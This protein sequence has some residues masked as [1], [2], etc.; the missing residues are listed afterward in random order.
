MSGSEHITLVGQLNTTGNT[1]KDG[2]TG[3]THPTA[4]TTHTTAGIMLQIPLLSFI[5]S[6]SQFLLHQQE[7][8]RITTSTAHMDPGP[9]TVT[10]ERSYQIQ[11]DQQ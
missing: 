2:P 5:M 6:R 1:T 9:T 11:N 10:S 4:D 7:T 8:S 3:A